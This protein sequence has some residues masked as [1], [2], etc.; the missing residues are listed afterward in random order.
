MQTGKYILNCEILTQ[1]ETYSIYTH[2]YK[3][4]QVSCHN[5]KL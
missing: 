1:S 4:K 5:F 3:Y 2:K